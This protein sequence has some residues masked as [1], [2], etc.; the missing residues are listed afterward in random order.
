[1]KERQVQ[2]MPKINVLDKHV[3]ELIAAGEVVERPS[4]VIKELVEN[5]IDAGAS[6]VTVE[7]RRGGVTYMRVTDNGCGID[8]EDVATAFLRHATSKVHDKEDLDAI[9]TLGFRGEALAS[10]SAVSHVDLI[11]KTPDSTVGT[12]Y[13]AS[14]GSDV[15]VED[16]GCPNGTTITVRDIFY[17]VPAR[18]K[19]LKKDTAEGNAV[20]GLLDKIALSHPEISFRLIRDGKE[21]L[22]TPG[23]GKL[24]SAIY[25]VFGKEF[26][27]NLLPVD[28]TFGGIRVHGYVSSP[29]GSRPNRSMQN[30]FINGRFVRSRTAAVALEEAYKG[31]IMVGKF[32]ACVLHLEL[33]SEVVDVN[34][35]PAK[36]EVRFVHE[37]P[38]FDAVYHGVK[39]AVSASRDMKSI[40]LAA[41]QKPLAHPYKPDH[42]EKPVQTYIPERAP[43]V[44]PPKPPVQPAP[45]PP[46]SVEPESRPAPA[47]EPLGF[48]DSAPG[49]Y[50][51]ALPEIRGAI[52]R[53]LDHEPQPERPAEPA[54][55]PEPVPPDIAVEP[56]DE[57]QPVVV[58]K[59][60]EPIPEMAPAAE[61]AEPIPAPPVHRVIGEAFDTYIILQY[62]S[63][64][65]MFIDKHAAHE[66]LLYEKLRSRQGEAC[67]QTLLTPVTVTLDKNEYTAVLANLQ[68]FADAGFDVEDFGSG[69]VL[70]RSAPLNLDGADI[71]GS[72]LEMAGYLE[73]NRHD[74]T[75]EHMD[76]L[77]HNIACRAAI[78]GGSASRREEL[79]ALAERLEQNPE[80]RYCPHG[81]PIYVML[82][83]KT[84]EKE[85]GRLG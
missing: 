24:V 3:A 85:F 70:V 49:R 78:K 66:R 80:V 7:I 22:H 38:V 57:P 16:A 12:H 64:T 20:A 60:E 41:R 36:L 50:E 47:A 59:A 56:E 81:R 83:K 68:V 30:F 52:D 61:A 21:T 13:S 27:S 53:I 29:L 2:K 32:P 73:Q 48:S 42:M 34:V 58:P 75:T 46:R 23:D 8:R 51:P 31:S 72:V 62:D 11:T 6:I 28:Y 37:R 19:F 65:L 84:L 18:M 5:S 69:T 26:S 82:K 9:L 79:I 35:H 14:G 74:V 71:E 43:A 63:E 10:I 17:N 25:A 55:F 4:S 40:D 45:V 76:W 15:A 54:R 33:P 67:A 44:V 77:Y 1:M 39:S